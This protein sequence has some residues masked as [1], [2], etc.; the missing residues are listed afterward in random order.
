[1]KQYLANTVTGIRILGSILLAFVPAFSASFYA[2]YLLCGLSDIL[3]GAIAR[4]TGGTSSFG[5]RFD[6]IADIL[7]AAVS[8]VKLLPHLPV[9]GWLWGL[10][11]VDCG[12]QGLQRGCGATPVSN[13]CIRAFCA[14][15]TGRIFSVPAPADV[16]SNRAEIQRRDRMLPCN[17]GSNAGML[18]C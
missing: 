6:T 4:K 11:R 3:D 1:M 10:D 13:A 17:T 12:G 15:Q 2:F 9:P 8:L 16:W 5:A 18:L 14:E 7:F